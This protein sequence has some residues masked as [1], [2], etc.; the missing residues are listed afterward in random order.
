[1]DGPAPD[2]AV[3]AWLAERHPGAVVTLVT[4]G[5]SD[6]RKYRVVTATDAWLYRF[7]PLAVYARKQAEF[8]Q[9]ARLNGLTD[10]LPHAVEQGSVPEH[11]LCFVVYEWCE[12]T[13]AESELPR[14]DEA[15]Q[16][17]HGETAGKLLQLIHALPQEEQ[18]DARAYVR[19]KIDL[20]R[21]E[22]KEQGLEFE[23]YAAM[24][25]FLERNLPL[26]GGT[27]TVFRHGDFHLGNMLVDAR[28]RLRVI[29]LNRS[30]F[31]D[32]IEDFNRL[33][34]FSRQV[35]VPFA[36]GQIHGYFGG[37]PPPDFFAHALCYVLLDCA[38]GLLWARRFGAREI[39]VQHALTAQIMGDFDRLRA[40]QP[41]W[42]TAD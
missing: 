6:D 19:R 38:F 5:W 3:A 13:A 1:M 18:V 29:D 42:L 12:G 37:P 36:R 11:D 40:P 21:R 7:S 26:L 39:A 8:R 4:A 15:E 41:R 23:G 34:T 31:G 14:R 33:F 35:S 32:P 10:A 17:R 30:D 27:P 20:R 16:Y 24:I 2:S 28:G 22:M 9:V 25:E